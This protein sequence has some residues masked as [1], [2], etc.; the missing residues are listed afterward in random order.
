MSLCSFS[1]GWSTLDGEPHTVEPCTLALPF[2]P[3]S[4]FHA[5]AEDELVVRRADELEAA[6]L[7]SV[8]R[9]AARRRDWHGVESALKRAER[10]A[11]RNPWVAE[12]IKEL[13]ELAAQKDELLFAK[14]SAFA[15]SRM[16][17]RLA[18][19]EEC[20]SVE[21]PAPAAYLRRKSA[22]GK[23]DPKSPQR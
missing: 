23:R 1:L 12:S 13:R 19:R 18:A 11:A 21:I 3:T 8:A 17:T 4:A 5:I 14:E 2:M 15:A 6:K 7:Q 9:I 20:A 10:I 16:S 22:Q